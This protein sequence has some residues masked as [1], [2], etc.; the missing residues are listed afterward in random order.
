VFQIIWSR[1]ALVGYSSILNY[2]DK[3]WTDREVRKFEKEVKD[4][5]LLLSHNPNLLQPIEKNV[6]RGPLNS[7]TMIT[8]QINHTEK[9]IYL[10]NMRSSRQKP[11]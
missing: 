6:R 1:R 4:F 5:L 9:V 8:Y 10:L 11:Y 7:L 2:I 3:H